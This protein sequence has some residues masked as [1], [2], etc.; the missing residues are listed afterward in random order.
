VRHLP[1]APPADLCTNEETWMNAERVDF[2][3]QLD[4]LDRPPTTPIA[5]TQTMGSPASVGRDESTAPRLDPGNADDWE[6]IA[7]LRSSF[8]SREEGDAMM[9]YSRDECLALDTMSR[10][11]PHADNDGAP[12]TSRATDGGQAYTRRELTNVK[13]SNEHEMLMK[14]HIANACPSVRRGVPVATAST[15]THRH[16]RGRLFA[17]RA[18]RST[19]EWRAMADRLWDTSEMPF[20]RDLR[21]RCGVGCVS[22]VG[23]LPCLVDFKSYARVASTRRRRRGRPTIAS[24]HDASCPSA[25]H[26]PTVCPISRR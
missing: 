13:P 7:H 15:S 3:K 21:M 12:A 5:T 18:Q 26:F 10:A 19:A 24:E 16:S 14:R 1:D 17:I 2:G 8:T 20:M 22:H 25:T 23:P 4:L 9:V 11:L 6:A